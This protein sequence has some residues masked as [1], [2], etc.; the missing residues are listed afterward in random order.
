M[1]YLQIAA[2]VVSILLGLAQ[3]T[4]EGQPLMQKIQESRQQALLNQ[5]QEEA[6]RRA[7][8][9]SNMGIQ[10]QYRGNDGTWRFYSDHTGRYWCRVNIQGVYEYTE[11]P[12]YIASTNHRN[13]R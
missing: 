11:S 9:I 12:H 6:V 10:W 13:V 7:T 5:Q 8:E 3:M 1:L 4:K 2:A